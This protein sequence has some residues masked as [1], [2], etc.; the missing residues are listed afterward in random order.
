[1]SSLTRFRCHYRGRLGT[2]FSTLLGLPTCSYCTL[3]HSAA[4][5]CTLLHSAALITPVNPVLSA[6]GHWPAGTRNPALYPTELR[7]HAAHPTNPRPPRQDELDGKEDSHPRRGTKS[8]PCCPDKREI[9]PGSAVLKAWIRVSADKERMC[10]WCSYVHGVAVRM[11]FLCAPYSE[12]LA[13]WVP[14]PV[15][16]ERGMDGH[17]QARTNTDR[18]VREYGISQDPPIFPCAPFSCVRRA[19]MRVILPCALSSRKA[20]IQFLRG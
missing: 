18:M 2:L 10:A 8:R 3:L 15:L 14:W 9:L 19:A 12:G 11:V 20:H 5:C 1:V 17:G 6:E 16:S 13:K 7:G 4:L